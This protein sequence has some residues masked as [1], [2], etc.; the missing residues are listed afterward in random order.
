MRSRCR[1]WRDRPMALVRM[2]HGR[3]SPVW[4][5]GRRRFFRARTMLA[6]F[7]TCT[8]NRST[9][10]VYVRVAAERSRTVSYKDW[11]RWVGWIDRE[12]TPAPRC[13][14]TRTSGLTLLVEVLKTMNDE[15][16]GDHQGHEE[17]THLQR[18]Q[19]RIRVRPRPLRIPNRPQKLLKHNLPQHCVLYQQMAC[20]PR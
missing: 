7:S 17:H 19:Q 10:P 11:S 16:R 2:R 14:R 6:S 18:R 9:T 8:R 5:M 3:R 1:S 12:C 13:A 20:C 15:E 4:G